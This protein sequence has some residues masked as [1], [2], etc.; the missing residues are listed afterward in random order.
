MLVQLACYCSCS[1]LFSLLPFTTEL[2]LL[3]LQKTT[4]VVSTLLG[5]FLL[6]LLSRSPLFC[7][8]KLSPSFSFPA[9]SLVP[10]KKLPFV[11]CV[12]SSI[13]RLEG[14][15]LLLRVGSRAR[16]SWSASGRAAG[17]RPV[18]AAPSV[19]AACGKRN[20]VKT[21]LFKFFFFLLYIFF[22]CGAQK[23]VTT[24]TSY[25]FLKTCRHTTLHSRLFKCLYWM[26]CFSNSSYVFFS[27]SRIKK[28]IKNIVLH[29]YQIQVV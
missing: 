12:E 19:L 9:L 1:P 11:A 29:C 2:L 25:V 3:P 5:P 24:T 27:T 10:S 14:R 15:G 21:T 13:Y 6:L 16:G 28:I 26:K 18:S 8:K 23:W 22:I 4:P 20:S 7:S 17:G